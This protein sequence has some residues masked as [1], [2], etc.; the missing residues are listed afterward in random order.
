MSTLV[1]HKTRGHSEQNVLERLRAP[2][3]EEQPG[4][5]TN[6][7]AALRE[8]R[9]NIFF[10]CSSQ[11]FDTFCAQGITT[12]GRELSF[13]LGIETTHARIFHPILASRI[14]DSR[15]KVKRVFVEQRFVYPPSRCW[16][17]DGEDDNWHCPIH[18]EPWSDSQAI[19]KEDSLPGFVGTNLTL[20]QHWDYGGGDV[21]HVLKPFTN[22]KG[23]FTVGELVNCVIE[24]ETDAR[25]LPR[26]HDGSGGL[27]V[28]AHHVYFEGFCEYCDTNGNPV[29]GHFAPSWGS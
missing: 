10:L 5:L 22:D 28:D 17:A 4:V 11:L 9:E 23:F 12:E 6:P 3:D 15:S 26:W 20:H 2:R 19:K 18:E 13:R 1:S 24:F 16:C 27:S 14:E 8:V 21:R 25:K 7:A 29:S